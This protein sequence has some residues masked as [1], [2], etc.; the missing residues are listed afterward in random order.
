MGGV[1]GVL[2]TYNGIIYSHIISRP[3]H[4][5]FENSYRIYIYILVILR[6]CCL[7]VGN[8]SIR[9]SHYNARQE[10]GCTQV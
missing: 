1:G 7:Y 5:I 2:L 8:Y 9:K 6:Q 4:Q 3:M 10:F